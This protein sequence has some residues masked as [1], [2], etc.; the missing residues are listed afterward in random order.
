MRVKTLVALIKSTVWLLAAVKV[1]SEY[2]IAQLIWFCCLIP[3]WSSDF[4]DASF[5]QK[6]II[7]EKKQYESIKSTEKY[8][9][10]WSY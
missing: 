5:I 7:R 10:A 6:Y 2:N 8:S 9:I 3:W 1:F 4:R